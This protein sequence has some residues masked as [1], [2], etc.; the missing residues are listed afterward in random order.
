MTTP[1]LHASLAFAGYSDPDLDNFAA[2]HVI[3]M[4]DNPAFTDPT[5]KPVDMGTLQQ[6][7]HL[8]F[9]A[10]ANGGTDLTAAKNEAREPLVNALRLN[11]AYVQGRPGLTLSVLLS[12]GFLSTNTNHAQSQLDTP[13]ITG[14]DNG[15]TTQLITHLTPITNSNSYQVK[16][17]NLD[18]TELKTVDC[19][20]ARNIVIPGLKPGVVYTLMG[21]WRLDKAFVV[22]AGSANAAARAVALLLARMG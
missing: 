21:E 10:A 14:I 6:T 11:A 3:C 16:V 15:A 9:L 12:S 17:L 2:K 5:V 7:F 13:S 20:Q 1:I 8:A 19:S 22:G 4:T 18:G